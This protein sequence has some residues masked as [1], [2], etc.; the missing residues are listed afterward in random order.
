MLATEDRD[1][2]REH[3]VKFDIVRNDR[4]ACPVNA[5]RDGE[6]TH[7]HPCLASPQGFALDNAMSGEDLVSVSQGHQAP[8]KM[9]NPFLHLMLSGSS[10]GSETA[11]R[12]LDAAQGSCFTSVDLRGLMWCP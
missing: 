8:V 4:N 12:L 10:I 9:D 6:A 3:F 7:T 1:Q 2:M 11:Q 5:R